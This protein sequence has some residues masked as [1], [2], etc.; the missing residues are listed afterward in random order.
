VLKL[1]EYNISS[2]GA[3]SKTEASTLAGP[4]G[5]TIVKLKVLGTVKLV[6]AFNGVLLSKEM[7]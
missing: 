6:L 5:W 3:L 2:S 7:G 4:D 1:H